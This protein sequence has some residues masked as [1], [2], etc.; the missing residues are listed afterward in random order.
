MPI[1]MEGLSLKENA[2]YEV[3]LGKLQLDSSRKKWVAAYPINIYIINNYAQA[4][5]CMI[6]MEKRLD[7]MGRIEKSNKQYQ[8]YID[9]RDY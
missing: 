3:I 9:G 4:R 7:I 1:R 6:R 5:S 2:E 8:D